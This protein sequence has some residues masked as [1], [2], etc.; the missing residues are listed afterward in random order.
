SDDGKIV[1]ID[2]STG[3]TMA[4]RSWRGGLHQAIEIKES[5]EVTSDKENLARLSFQRF[6]R[7]YPHLAGM[8]GTAWE[9]RGELWQ[10]FN[11]AVVRVP[12][13]K[14]LIRQQL[15][16][17]FYGTADEKWNAVVDRVA[18]LHADGKPVLI[19]T[20][21][22]WSSEEVDR[23]LAERG[24]PHRVL[25]ARQDKQEA[26]VV[27]QAG[28]PGAITVAT[29]MAGRGT[30]ILLGRGVRDNG[31]LNVIA[32]EP[33]ASGRIDR[34]LFGRAG[35][36]GDPGTAQMFASAEDDLIKRHVDRLRNK[37]RA[38]GGSRLIRIAQKRAEKLARFNRK[39]VLRS[40]DWM[41]QSLPF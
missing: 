26:E 30:D 35:R 37:W 23:R 33:H 20:R 24:L 5:V 27:A 6:F 17:K 39:Q 29:N 16:L 28:Q 18:E 2:E 21:S 3:R 22:V 7:Q 11:K 41:D 8:T 10:I 19:G 34:Q 36:Q 4:D 1:I 32:T 25:N 13:N 40:D 31:G 12:T 15:P 14:P 9:A 38:L